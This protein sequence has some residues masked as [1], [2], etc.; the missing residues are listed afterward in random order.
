MI[1]T[2]KYFKQV[3]FFIAL[4]SFTKIEQKKVTKVSKKKIAVLIIDGQNNHKNWQESTPIMKQYLEET[5]LFE[6]TVATT[7][8]SGENMEDFK[9]NF[10][11]FKVVVSNYNGDSWSKPTNEAFENF[12]KNGNGFVS[13]HAADNAFPNWEAYNKMI[14]IGG[15]NGRNKKAGPY[16]YFDEQ[17]QAIVKDT[18]AGK[19]GYHGSRHAF[20]IKIRNATHPITKGMPLVWLHETDELYEDLRGPAENLDVLATAFAAKD[21]KG[22]EKHEPMLMTITYGKGKIFHT[23]LGHGNDSQSCVGFITLLQ[24]GTEWVATG[25]VT[26]ALPKDFPTAN[27][28]STRK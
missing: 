7:P 10:S 11:K 18:A 13:I 28:V 3:I 17:T 1:A 14:G 26:Q 19:T 4:F 20:E 25:K 21:Q 27:K 6:V 15:W 2:M 23:T 16:V 12:V 8:P 24:R 9:P 22:E 5:G